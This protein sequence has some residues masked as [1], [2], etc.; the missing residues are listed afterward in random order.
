MYNKKGQKH[1]KSRRA[2]GAPAL[3]VWGRAPNP[4][5]R[6]SN[7]QH[8]KIYMYICCITYKYICI[9]GKKVVTL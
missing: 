3:G 2:A 1:T 4:P 7:E 8:T 6:G 9:Y 5:Q